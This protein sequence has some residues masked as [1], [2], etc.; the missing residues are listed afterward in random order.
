MRYCEG[1]FKKEFIPEIA[2]IDEDD[3]FYTKI[4]TEKL[5]EYITKMAGY[6]W[7]LIYQI[8]VPYGKS[9]DAQKIYEK[10]RTERKKRS[11]QHSSKSN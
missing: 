2:K 4:L 5:N 8:P 9:I 10:I 6:S 1:L 11:E 7:Q 3:D